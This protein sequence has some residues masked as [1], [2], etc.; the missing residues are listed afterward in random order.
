VLLDQGLSLTRDG[1]HRWWPVAPVADVVVDFPSI[2]VRFRGHGYHDVN[3]GDAPLEASFA[4]WHWLRARSGRDA[5]L[6]YDVVEA[7]GSSSGVAL[8]IAGSG[9]IASIEA[10]GPVLPRSA[11]G[12]ERRARAD[13]GRSAT[14]VRSLEDGPFYA[15]A[16]VETCLGGRDVVAMQET[17][18]ARRLRHAWVRFLAGF[19][20][21]RSE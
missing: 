5:L 4:T 17:L 9:T 12:L 20:M 2:G 15:R 11:W 8:R 3:A 18:D 1:A 10:G 6:A 21:R 7:N 19:R 13:A 16:L 14:I